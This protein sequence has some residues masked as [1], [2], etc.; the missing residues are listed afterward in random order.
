MHKE[1][2]TMGKIKIKTTKIYTK[3]KFAL[4]LFFEKRKG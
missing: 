3:R 2:K 4:F 1:S